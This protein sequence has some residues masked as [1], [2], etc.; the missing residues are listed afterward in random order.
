MLL[1]THILIEWPALYISYHS[2]S[3]G[4]D[5]AEPEPDVA[6]GE[7]LFIPT[8]ALALLDVLHSVR[9]NHRLVCIYN[10]RLTHPKLKP[11]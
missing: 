5:A 2:Y 10:R 3:A 4:A 6:E 1:H 7:M 11:K 8:A 9:P